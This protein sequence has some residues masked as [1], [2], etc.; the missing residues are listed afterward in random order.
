M[1]VITVIAR[2]V[3]VNRLFGVA[4]TAAEGNCPIF[5]EIRNDHDGCMC[6]VKWA[7]GG[8]RLGEAKVERCA[9]YLEARML[10]RGEACA[11]AVGGSSEE[12]QTLEPCLNNPGASVWRHGGSLR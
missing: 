4:R 5:Q 2:D 7:H 10:G 11:A 9:M 12:T 3:A 6:R 1:A 8:A